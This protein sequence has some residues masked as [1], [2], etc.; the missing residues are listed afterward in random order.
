MQYVQ[1]LVVILL[2]VRKKF[3]HKNPVY[4]GKN[5]ALFQEKI[6]H[7]NLRFNHRVDKVPGFFSSRPKWDPPPPLHPLTRWRVCPLPLRFRGGGHSRLRERGW[8]S[9][10]SDEGTDTVVL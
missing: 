5:K 4:Q 2:L 8:G 10:H 3:L 7:Y 9:P 1:H 6:F